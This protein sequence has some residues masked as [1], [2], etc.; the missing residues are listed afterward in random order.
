MIV[1]DDEMVRNG[2]AD[3]L[4]L[5][6]WKSDTAYGFMD[7]LKKIKENKYI[8]FILDMKLPDGSGIALCRE[9]RK[10][11]DAPVLFLSALDNE[12][13]IVEGFEAGGND[14]VIKP[15]RTF[16]LLARVKALLNRAEASLATRTKSAVK[17]GDF[18]LDLKR[19]CVYK[20]KCLLELTLTE[21]RILCCLITNAP[22]LI[23]RTKLLEL[24]WD[25][26]ESYVDD[27]ALS[28]YIA[29]IRRKITEN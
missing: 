28:V 21:Y 7:A 4:Q 26:Y 27:N 22:Q 13:Y 17:S 29:R 2:I 10:R 23:E 18:L 19:Q 24:I 14:Y 16:E 15:F 20:N 8:L 5:R 3:A 1:E 25:A 6:S 11:T 12:G 9:I